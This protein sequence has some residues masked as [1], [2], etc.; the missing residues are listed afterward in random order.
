MFYYGAVDADKRIGSWEDR[1]TSAWYVDV[2]DL[3]SPLLF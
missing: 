1:T 3:S 2:G